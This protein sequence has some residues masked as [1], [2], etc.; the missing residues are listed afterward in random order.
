MSLEPLKRSFSPAILRPNPMW[1]P[2]GFEIGTLYFALF[3][4]PLLRVQN[5]SPSKVSVGWLDVREKNRDAAIRNIRSLPQSVSDQTSKILLHV[6]R[7]T[8][9]VTPSYIDQTGAQFAARADSPYFRQYFDGTFFED[10]EKSGHATA[11]CIDVRNRRIHFQDPQ[12][13]EF[14]DWVKEAFEESFPD[15]SMIDWSLKQQHDAHSCSLHTVRN[16]LAL[17][18]EGRIEPNV[19]MEAWRR[20]CIRILTLFEGLMKRTDELKALV[21][22]DRPNLYF[23]TSIMNMRH[24]PV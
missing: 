8:T 1:I 18:T 3:G 21:P 17:K 11:A 10:R 9:L 14:Y 15:F 4:E 19:D 16:L 5:L 7:E 23:M 2:N 13:I 22:K 24:T 6:S 20:E 12:G